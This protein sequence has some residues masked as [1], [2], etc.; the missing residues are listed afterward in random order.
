MISPERFVRPSPA[1]AHGNIVNIRPA[2]SANETS[3]IFPVNGNGI[4]NFK[5][6]RWTGSADKTRCSLRTWRCV[7]CTAGVQEI[8]DRW[9][10][11]RVRRR[12]HAGR[13]AAKGPTGRRRSHDI[14]AAAAAAAVPE[15]SSVYTRLDSSHS[16]ARKLCRSPVFFSNRKTSNQGPNA[17]P[18]LGFGSNGA[19]VAH[20]LVLMMIAG[21]GDVVV[22]LAGYLRL[23]AAGGGAVDGR[24]R[25]R[26]RLGRTAVLRLRQRRTAAVAVPVQTAAVACSRETRIVFFSSLELL[27]KRL[28]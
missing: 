4:S 21:R 23:G 16:S 24:R 27:R 15:N 13:G 2:F 11:C 5:D 14:A 9:A 22:V 19:R 7:P 12:S 17:C 20:L 18:T 28:G 3:M 26:R 6:A 10:F 1:N 25:R 8:E